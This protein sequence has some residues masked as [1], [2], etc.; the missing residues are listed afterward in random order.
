MQNAGIVFDCSSKRNVYAYVYPND[1]YKIY[2]GR[3]YWTAPAAGTDSQAGTL[4]HE[5]SH[6]T[7]VAGT[8]DVVYGQTGAKSLAIS[9]PDAA[10]T[11]AD[12][13]EYF[14]ENYP[15]QS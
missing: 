6:F 10:I 14:A 13:H 3:V 1:P 4:I 7:N 11:N 12:S 2:L 9:N 8:D 15:A 5:M